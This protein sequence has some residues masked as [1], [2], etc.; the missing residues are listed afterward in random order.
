MNKDSLSPETACFRQLHKTLQLPLQKLSKHLQLILLRL[1][2]TT[3]W[4]HCKCFRKKHFFKGLK[5]HKKPQASSLS[6]N[7]KLS[8]LPVQCSASPTPTRSFVWCPAKLLLPRFSVSPMMFPA[9][10]CP[11]ITAAMWSSCGVPEQACECRRVHPV[12]PLSHIYIFYGRV[13]TRVMKIM[14][15]SKRRQ[16][17][18]EYRGKTAGREGVGNKV[19]IERLFLSCPALPGAA[20]GATDGC[21]LPALGRGTTPLTAAGLQTE[22]VT[23][24][25]SK[26]HTAQF[27][28]FQAFVVYLGVSWP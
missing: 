10:A 24:C 2:L 27:H 15:K 21:A 25:Y 6:Y 20:G 9:P 5:I 18:D 26:C 4:Y 14:F 17:F 7:F 8:K 28:W 23:A 22:W 13:S 11:G 16:I 1:H 12:Y 3:R 19:W